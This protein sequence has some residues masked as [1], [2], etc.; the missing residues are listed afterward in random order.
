MMAQLS[1]ISAILLCLSIWNSGL[2]GLGY[3]VPEPFID[4]QCLGAV[5]GTRGCLGEVVK[6][7]LSF[8]KL[9]VGPVCCKAVVGVAE[10]CW[11]QILP[12]NTYVIPIIK[13][14]CRRHS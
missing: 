2:M 4:F 3:G 5:V 6:A 1:T 14:Y 10:G 12:F 7:V 8:H 9:Q 11:P 13:N